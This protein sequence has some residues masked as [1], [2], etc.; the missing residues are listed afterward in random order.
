MF[1]QTISTTKIVILKLTTNKSR[2]FLLRSYP[3]ILLP[4]ETF[5]KSKV[6]YY[7]CMIQRY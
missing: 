2:Y 7:L 4:N 3:H 6:K 1:R 5:A